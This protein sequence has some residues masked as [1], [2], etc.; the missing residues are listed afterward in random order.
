MILLPRSKLSQCESDSGFFLEDPDDILALSPWND[1]HQDLSLFIRNQKIVSAVPAIRNMILP[2]EA[3]NLLISK[4]SIKLL[5]YDLHDLR[6]RVGSIQCFDECSFFRIF[7][8]LTLSF[9]LI[10]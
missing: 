10:F 8:K 7:E 5:I 6:N 3:L 2:E 1:L 9:S 4:I